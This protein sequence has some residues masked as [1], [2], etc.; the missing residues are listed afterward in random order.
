MK[1]RNYKEPVF[2]CETPKFTDSPNCVQNQILES[3]IDEIVFEAIRCKIQIFAE[4]GKQRH[5]KSSLSENM[6]QKISEQIQ[7]LQKSLQ[8][9]SH[10]RML[11]YES[12]KDEK[13]IR[14]NYL[15]ERE[16][17]NSQIADTEQ[18]I[19]ALELEFEKIISDKPELIEQK[20][21]K[22]EKI[23]S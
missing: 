16:T 12:Y 4:N 5:D 9:L 13:I 10:N 20:Y 3:D 19:Q 2:I 17:F 6:K 18:K 8:K 23:Q 15:T 1:K 22:F 11:L 21:L 14:E 7:E